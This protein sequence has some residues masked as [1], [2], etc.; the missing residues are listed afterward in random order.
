[1]KVRFYRWYNAVLT[2]LLSMLGYGCSTSSEE[3]VE[4]YGVLVVEYGTP[5]AEYRV[6]GQV[7]DESG[8]PINGIK[9][10]AK[11]VVAS[12]MSGVHGFGLDS[13]QTDA[14]G[15]FAVSFRCFPGNPET[16]LIV[17]DI[18]GDANGGEFLSDTLDIDFNKAVQTTKGEGWYEGSFEITQ[19]IKMKKK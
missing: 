16:K 14:S 19:D 12:G 4:M 8:V 17:E 7:T 1:M 6:K 15:Q 18:D 11:N 9:T 13:V 3:D 10:S 2:V 5:Y